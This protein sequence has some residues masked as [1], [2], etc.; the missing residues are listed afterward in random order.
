MCELVELNGGQQ[1]GDL[2]DLHRQLHDWALCGIG[3]LEL[4]ELRAGYGWHGGGWIN[5]GE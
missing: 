3:E 5:Y 2:T 4:H 1:R